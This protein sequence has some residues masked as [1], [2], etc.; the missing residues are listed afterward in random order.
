MFEI[1]ST[2]GLL[3]RV[4]QVAPVTA[5]SD[6]PLPLPE[7]Q[8]TD[9]SLQVE[10]D[11]ADAAVLKREQVEAVADAQLQR[12]RDATD[13]TKEVERHEIDSTPAPE[14]AVERSLEDERLRKERAAADEVLATERL[15]RKQSM[16]DFL[17]VER[18]ATDQD[19]IEERK[20]ADTVIAARDE[21]LAT[22][23]HELRSYLSSLAL[24]AQLLHKEAP[25]GPEGE[26]ARRHANT[27]RRLVTRMNR[28]INDL[29]D[30]GSIEAGK[31]SMVKREVDLSQLV[32]ETLESFATIAQAAGVSLTAKKAAPLL[33]MVDP[34]RVLQVLANLV[35][36]A[37]KFTPKGG[38]VEVRCVRAQNEARLEVSDSGIGI[39]PES[40]T[41][42]FARFRQV[43]QD[44]R[45]L[46]L[47]LHISKNI[48]EAHGG[49]LWAESTVK[50][51]STFIV[52][53]PLTC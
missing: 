12:T 49:K 9:E 45:G 2:G 20:R 29:L 3:S 24:S 25:T 13:L 21:F 11:I 1:S 44:R 31:L 42:I 27:S 47:G 10:R 17:A 51:G 15:E 19:L 40:L 50:V 18:E 53:I 32:T 34:D 8:R 5:E 43:T 4:L 33:A 36:N 35:A 48:V 28:L 30:I 14:V 41:G 26:S 39:P 16:A 46:G 37:I 22:V 6:K 23:S 7:R 52:V 38:H